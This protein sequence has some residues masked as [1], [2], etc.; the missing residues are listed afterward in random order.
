MNSQQV[1]LASIFLIV[2][3]AVA[4]GQAPQATDTP[5][6]TA[7]SGT[8]TD[9]SVMFGSDFD[10]PGLLSEIKLQHQHQS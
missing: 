5:L 3:R 1:L 2:L 7:S 4:S 9:L 6:Q 10:R 8:S